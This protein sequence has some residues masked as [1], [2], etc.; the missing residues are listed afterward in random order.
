MRV[1]QVEGGPGWINSDRFDISAKAGSA[2]TSDQLRRMLRTLLADRFQLALQREM[3]ELNVFALTINRDGPKLKESVSHSSEPERG[4]RI[5]GI[6]RLTG[7]AASSSQL[8]EA[9]SDVTLNGSSIVNRPVL[10]KTGLT[11][12]YDF[13]LSWL[14]DPGQVGN[15]AGQGEGAS[16]FTALVEQLGLKL[17]AQKGPVEILVIDHVEKPSEN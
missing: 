12:L 9:L 17:E 13:T 5:S 8:A 4:V 15:A 6:G 14:P 1:F 3:R 7:I 2:T 11:G 16:I 10:D